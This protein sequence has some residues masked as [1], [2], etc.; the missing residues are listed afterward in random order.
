MADRG[1]VV[2]APDPFRSEG[3]S[4]PRPWLIISNDSLPYPDEECIGVA[5]TTASHHR[6]SVRVASDDRVKGDPEGDS[7][8]LPWTVATLKEE[9]HV[10]GVQGALRGSFVGDIVGKTVAYIQ[11]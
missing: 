6:G 10:V 5:L 8:V 3:E 9:V 11:T 4:N 2:W 1:E 7:Y